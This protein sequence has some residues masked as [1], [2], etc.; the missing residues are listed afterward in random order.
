MKKI[1]VFSALR[2]NHFYGI[3]L[4]LALGMSGFAQSGRDYRS[5]QSPVKNQAN[6][7]TCTAFSILAAMET[8]PGF[9]VDLSEQYVYAHVKMEYYKDYT[10]YN[11]GAMLKYYIKILES[12]GT[13]REDLMPYKP[14]A[15]LWKDDL[16]N[17]DK[18]KKDLGG[19]PMF[20][21]LLIPD[22]TF[23]LSKT[24]YQ[25]RDFDNARD[26]E[27]IKKKL[28]EGYPS[29]P[30]AYKMNGRYW[31]QHAG[32]AKK[33]INLDDFL[34]VSY[35]DK[36]Y[37][38]STALNMIPD[39]P[40][41]I[42]TDQVKVGFTDNSLIPD[43]G[44]AVCITG[45]DENGFLIK[46]SWGEEWGDKGYGWISFDYHRLLAIEALLLISGKINGNPKKEP[47]SPSPGSIWL[48]SS[49]VLLKAN[50]ANGSPEQLAMS[51]SITYHG[52]GMV[53]RFESIEYKIYDE[54][55]RLVDTNF[56][57]TKGVYEG[58]YDGYETFVLLKENTSP[59]KKFT[60]KATFK[61]VLL[62][63]FTNTYEFVEKV[64]KEYEPEKH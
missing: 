26:V 56:G 39:L 21:L 14:D 10:E 22:Y 38:Y 29:I 54:N 46:N 19:T 58:V 45:Y 34:L 6:R 64:N 32:S 61:P 53:P 24:M 33:K 63:P 13:V 2:C 27:W 30:V 11:Q 28:D 18:M 50:P 57:R 12:D 8:L 35:Q 31:S 5:F 9:P 17:F 44:H 47:L 7:G 43:G 23:Q 52:S 62:E 37:P 3:L 36:F 41:K 25:Y 51:F 59:G 4:F 40:K 42:I 60:V 1:C 49:P 15:P 16:S 55:G 48:K 20:D